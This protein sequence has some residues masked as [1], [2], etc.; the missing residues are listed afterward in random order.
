MVTAK[1]WQLVEDLVTRVLVTA[2]GRI[3]VNSKDGYNYEEMTG[4]MYRMILLSSHGLRRECLPWR[5]R[6]SLED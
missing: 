3:P 2:E 5:N 4:R 6:Q 1:S